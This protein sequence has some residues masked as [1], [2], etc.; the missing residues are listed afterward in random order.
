MGYSSEIQTLAEAADYP[1]PNS[2]GGRCPVCERN[3]EVVGA[4]GGKST[5]PICNY[6]FKYHHP[7]DRHAYVGELISD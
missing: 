6:C 4:F 7:D 5:C 3:A 2:N 1:M